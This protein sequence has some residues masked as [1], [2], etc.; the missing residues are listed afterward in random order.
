VLHERAPLFVRQSDGSIQNKYYLKVLN[1]MTENLPVKIS[2]S[3]PKNMILVGAEELIDAK[4]GGVTPTA[5]FVKVPYK[6]V[7]EETMPITFHVEAIGTDGQV[8]QS[9]RESIF[10]GPKR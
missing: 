9:S 1:K 6:D 8:Y 7:T 2:A 5:V 4:R 10:I 3:G